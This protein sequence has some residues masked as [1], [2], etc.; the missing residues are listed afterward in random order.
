MLHGRGCCPRKG[1]EFFIGGGDEC[2]M[3]GGL[4]GEAVMSVVW[5]GMSAKG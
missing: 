5:E 2:C 4:V 1:D 3:R